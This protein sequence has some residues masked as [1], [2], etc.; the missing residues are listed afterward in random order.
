MNN[1]SNHN[2]DIQ[3]LITRYEGMV[4]NH[5]PIYIDSDEFIQIIE[6]YILEGRLGDALSAIA[7]A[8]KS[9]STDEQIAEIYSNLLIEE[10]EIEEAYD[11]VFS[12]TIELTIGI[13]L[14]RGEVLLEM[15][16]YKEAKAEYEAALKEDDY[17]LHTFVDIL[18][19]YC[20]GAYAT[21]GESFL[22]L[23]NQKHPVDQLI[24]T[25]NDLRDCLLIY[26]TL[27]S[28]FKECLEISE[29]KTEIEPYS[30]DA[31]F[32]LALQFTLNSQYEKAHQAIDFGLAIEPSN[33]ELYELKSTL[34]IN[35]GTDAEIIDHLQ[36][37]ISENKESMSASLKLIEHYIQRK[38]H[39]KAHQYTTELLESGKATK[40]EK[41]HLLTKMSQ[42]ALL[43][44]REN[45]AHLY[46]L[47]AIRANPNSA[48]SYTH[49]GWCWL[50]FKRPNKAI[51]KKFF[52]LSCWYSHENDLAE[53]HFTIG[54]L[55]FHAKL[56]E[57]AT[58][59]LELFTEISQNELKA[60]PYLLYTY[61]L[62]NNH[63]KMKEV[64]KKIKSENS[65]MYLKLDEII[66]D[67]AMNNSEID[68]SIF[69]QIL[70]KEFT[71]ENN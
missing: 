46:A 62:E 60:Y 54:Q 34:L 21:E 52:E 45:E 29:I 35:F 58:N 57:Q 67:I 11:I 70:D 14:Q 27:T 38:E 51:A 1:S 39:N 68:L 48:V 69:K 42:L 55:Y 41:E 18:T 30:C 33:Q 24:R 61:Y 3:E 6:F 20:K 2:L 56:Y 53:T 71:P 5:T 25:D 40:E 65:L 12:E 59:Y 47:R 49:Y 15:E 7:T 43:A 32:N 13:R 44:G 22:K 63:I 19:S 31:W 66:N 16:K 8:F 4:K 36:K 9:Y 37:G 50:S 17:S 64:I 26:Y 23:L 28:R 10:G